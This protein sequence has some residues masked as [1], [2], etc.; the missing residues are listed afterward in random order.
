MEKFYPKYFLAANSCEGFVSFFCEN[1]SA[2]DGWRAYIIKGG[3]GT[4]KSSFMKYI[5][6]RA[7]DAGYKATL[8][9][10]SSDPSSLDGV[11][12]EEKKIIFLDGTAPHTVEPKFPGICEEIINLGE[13][14]DSEKLFE[15]RK[16]ILKISLENKALHIS[17]ARYLAA[18]EGLML[19]NLK[20]AESFTD[21]T[22][23]QAAA[24]RLCRRLI[25]KKNKKDAV[26]REW[27]R[28]AGGITPL[29]IVAYEKTLTE[30]YENIVVI[31]DKY[32]SVSSVMLE[33]IREFALGE[34]YEI[35]TLKSPFLPEK[36]TDHIIIPELS[37]C[38]VTE[39]EYFKPK[40]NVRRIHA[41]RFTDIQAVK[42]HRSRLLFN[43]RTAKELLQTACKMLSNAKSVHDTLEKHYTSAMDFLSCTKK[44]QQ[45][46]DKIFGS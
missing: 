46:A 45:I 15:D 19:D 24:K 44:A 14:W 39:N 42:R 5:A 22:Y 30:N 35:I 13:F 27:V 8:C 40:C 36:L 29:G 3:P 43:R 16:Q 41:R 32:G 33:K 7:T 26:G 20:I 1:Y 17:A 18:C 10:C 12:I 21:K 2:S 4:G 31:E 25:P 38:F 11:I 9:V 23:V 37:L 6:S 28:F 34:G